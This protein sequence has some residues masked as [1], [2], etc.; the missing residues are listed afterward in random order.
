MKKYTKHLISIIATLSLV[1]CEPFSGP[2]YYLLKYYKNG[3]YA[4]VVEEFDSYEECVDF[5]Q[6]VTR[7]DRAIGF[8]QSV[9][10]CSE[11]KP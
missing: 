6:A 1:A 2:T 5:Q 7:D 9:F 8:T 3:S 4:G 10:R 11:D